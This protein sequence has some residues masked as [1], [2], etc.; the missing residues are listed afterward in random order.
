MIVKV[1][2]Y[3]NSQEY[4]LSEHFDVVKLV[5]AVEKVFFVQSLSSSETRVQRSQHQ[6]T[7]HTD[8]IIY[9]VK[10]NVLGIVGVSGDDL[11]DDQEEHHGRNGIGVD[12]RS[13]AEPRL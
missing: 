2:D 6:Q 12:E 13:E 11:L 3:Q 5:S 1:N 4:F 9:S 7:H 10:Y 8:V